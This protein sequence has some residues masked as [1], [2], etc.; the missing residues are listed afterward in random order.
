MQI[1]GT[2]LV[3]ALLSMAGL[4]QARLVTKNV[5]YRDG[6]T[7]LEGY[8]AYDDSKARRPCV[9]LVHDWTGLDAYEK[10]RADQLAKLGYTVLAADI[11]GRGVRPKDV[12]GYQT[13]SGKYSA[14]RTLTRRRIFAALK[15]ASG[16]VQVDKK[17]IAAIGYC[18]GGM[19]V[20][21]LARG[22]APVDAVVSFHGNLSNPTPSEA[23]N[24]KTQVL[25]L[26]GAADPFVPKQQVAA[27]E[28]EM[29]AAKKP[30]KL[31]AY[32]GAVHSFTLKHA[33][34]NPKSGA[35]YHAEADKKSWAEMMAFFKKHVK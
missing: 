4:S 6:G 29:K 2:L 21:E 8:M 17:R 24:I 31:V 1:R 32:P 28:K 20:L 9:I 23:R 18:F 16:Q 27:F 10:G 19:V 5:L 3:L 35:A 11:Y 22:G 12:K 34:N 25:V 26:H 14:D 30:Y 15:Y 13:E 7:V 33:G